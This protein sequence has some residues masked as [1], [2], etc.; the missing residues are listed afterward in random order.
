MLDLVIVNLKVVVLYGDL[1]HT[2]STLTL[3]H[4]FLERFFYIL[5][6]TSHGRKNKT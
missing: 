2:T 6:I 3:H 5:G 1:S 4:E